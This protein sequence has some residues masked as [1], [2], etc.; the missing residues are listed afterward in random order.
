MQRKPAI[1]N[2]RIEIFTIVGGFLRV[3]PLGLCKTNYKV[4]TYKWNVYFLV[5]GMMTWG[6]ILFFHHYTQSHFSGLNTLLQRWTHVR[7]F[8]SHI[9]LLQWCCSTTGAQFWSAFPGS[10]LR[11]SL[12]SGKFENSKLHP[13]VDRY[14][15]AY[16]ELIV[17]AKVG[18][19]CSQSC[20]YKL[21]IT[22]G[23]QLHP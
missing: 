4:T 5:P 2:S 22:F 13:Y 12:H 23:R 11:T 10:L 1:P 9:C 6:Y 18:A 19:I 20:S 21:S 8:N 3:C 16:V 17:F 14:R 15:Y 7:P